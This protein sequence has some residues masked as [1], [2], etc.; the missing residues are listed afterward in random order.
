[1]FLVAGHCVSLSASKPVNWGVGKNERKFKLGDRA[2][3]HIIP[4]RLTCFN[5]SEILAEKF[6][7]FGNFVDATDNFV[8]DRVIVAGKFKTGGFDSFSR[9][10]KRLRDE[11]MRLVRKARAFGRR[12]NKTTTVVE[13]IAR[14]RGKARVPH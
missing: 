14:Q 3:E 1:M 9:R 10:N 6:S 2:G 11:Q 5:F 12:E 8:A 13:R 7:I 4:N